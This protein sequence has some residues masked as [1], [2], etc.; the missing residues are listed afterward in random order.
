M[1]CVRGRER[2]TSGHPA[3]A[4][5]SAEPPSHQTFQGRNF[6]ICSFVPRRLDYDLQ[7]VPVPYTTRAPWQRLCR[8]GGKDGKIRLLSLR[9]LSPAGRKGGELQ[10]IST[11]G[12]TDLFT[13][14]AVLH[15]D[16]QKWLFV[17]DNAGLAAWT[18][19]GGRLR[20]AWSTNTPGTSPVVAGGL[21]YA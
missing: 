21:L 20:P 4:T 18:L 10:T 1:A 19:V 2:V 9:K 13:A 8:A 14:P 12:A 7:A 15:A 3:F 11:H 6:V 5:S 17:A 16:G